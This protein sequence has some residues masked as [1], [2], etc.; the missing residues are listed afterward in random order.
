MFLQ[1]LQPG[2]RLLGFIALFIHGSQLGIG[3]LRGVFFLFVLA[4]TL[5]VLYGRFVFDLAVA[6]DHIG[7]LV[8]YT[9]TL[10][11]GIGQFVVEILRGLHLVVDINGLSIE[12]TA[13][14]IS[15]EQQRNIDDGRE[16][17]LRLPEVNLVCNLHTLL[18]RLWY[19]LYL[20]CLS[21]QVH[22]SA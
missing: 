17:V 6:V 7:I 1:L 5:D 8:T 9:V 22:D 15:E 12:E 10:V 16:H 18:F 14:E 21:R 20:C 4:A 3:I 11:V 19:C 2:H 13:D